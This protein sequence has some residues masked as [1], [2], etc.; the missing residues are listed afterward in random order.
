M[1]IFCF[2]WRTW[3][4]RGPESSGLTHSTQSRLLVACFPIKKD[5]NLQMYVMKQYKHPNKAKQ[6]VCSQYFDKKNKQRK[7]RPN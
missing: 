7:D 3:R 1:N 5:P 4:L 2:L 6:A